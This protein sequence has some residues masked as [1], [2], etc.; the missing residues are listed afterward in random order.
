M[1]TANHRFV[2]QYWKLLGKAGIAF[3]LLKGLVW[4]AVSVTLF[5]MSVAD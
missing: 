3:F 1:I 5:L 2:K 4:L